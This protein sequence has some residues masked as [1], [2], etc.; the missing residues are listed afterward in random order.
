MTRF[1]G[2]GVS[3]M[4]K[5]FSLSAVRH[6]LFLCNMDLAVFGSVLPLHRRIAPYFSGDTRRVVWGY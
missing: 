4:T 2:A 3:A 6:A 5:R 1:I